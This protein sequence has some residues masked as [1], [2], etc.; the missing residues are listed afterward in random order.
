MKIQFT[1]LFYLSICTI[2]C[3]QTTKTKQ[4]NSALPIQPEVVFKEGN[5][6]E[7]AAEQWTSDQKKEFAD[8]FFIERGKFTI[9]KEPIVLKSFKIE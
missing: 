2:G 8:L 9:P 6:L 1:T 3:A 5:A 4:V 7:K